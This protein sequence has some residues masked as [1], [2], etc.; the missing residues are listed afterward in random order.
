LKPTDGLY[1]FNRGLVHA[2]LMNFDNAIQDFTDGIK[3]IK[4]GE[5]HF[6]AL[7]HRGNCYRQK[8]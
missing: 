6:K 7:F 3:Y 4:T 5:T 2:R 8:K 1:Y